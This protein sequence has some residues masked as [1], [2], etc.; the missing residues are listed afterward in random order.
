MKNPEMRKEGRSC[1]DHFR[2]DSVRQWRSPF[3]IRATIYN[4]SDSMLRFKLRYK[5]KVLNDLSIIKNLKI[6]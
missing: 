5:F 3:H 1:R 2:M 4:N 6:E